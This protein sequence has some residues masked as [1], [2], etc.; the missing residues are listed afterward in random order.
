MPPS[1]LP[2]KMARAFASC[3]FRGPTKYCIM[4]SHH[5]VKVTIGELGYDFTSLIP[6]LKKQLKT[7]KIVLFSELAVVNKRFTRCA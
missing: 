3:S 5:W 1:H 4:V 2:E 7:A 6:N